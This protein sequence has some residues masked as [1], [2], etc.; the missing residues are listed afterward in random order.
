MNAIG[1]KAM[2][3]VFNAAIGTYLVVACFSG[4]LIG[5]KTRA[6]QRET[7]GTVELHKDAST[8]SE[9]QNS[10]PSGFSRSECVA[11]LTSKEISP[12]YRLT[13]A[14][15]AARCDQIVLRIDKLSRQIVGKWQRRGAKG[16]IE[17][18]EISAGGK[19]R[20]HRYNFGSGK[21]E[22]AVEEWSIE[23]PAGTP[24]QEQVQ[25]GSLRFVGGE[26]TIWWSLKFSG[27]TMILETQPASAP[28]VE[29]WTRA[30]SPAQQRSGRTELR[31][32]LPAVPADDCKFCGVW[33][34]VVGG[35]SIRRGSDD[36]AGKT[37]NPYCGCD[38]LRITKMADRKFK[39]DIGSEYQGAV[40]WTADGDKVVNNADA[41]YLQPVNGKLVARFVS[42]N[43]YATHGMEFT[44][45]LSFELQGD[46]EL[47]F[48]V[49]C[50]IRRGETEQATFR[51]LD[52]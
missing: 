30:K 41:I 42:P 1:S 13:L 17:T 8:T 35:R 26:A 31:N 7:V 49:W 3:A 38:Y 45:K 52:R 21:M 9:S 15:A 39:L 24:G 5:Q 27:A 29:R 48:S 22:D 40:T 20:S 23:N 50:S 4:L 36:Y 14:Q 2:L 10:S 19:V 33:K 32:R 34:A 16:G 37:G 44:Y 25:F 18:I 47:V 46:N 11:H 43:F 12:Q 51:K 28:I 6:H